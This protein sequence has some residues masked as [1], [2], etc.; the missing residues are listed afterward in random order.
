[1][2]RLAVATLERPTDRV[3]VRLLSVPDGREQLRLTAHKVTVPHLAFTADGTLVSIDQ[4]FDACYHNGRTGELLRRVSLAADEA[5]GPEFVRLSPRG[6]WLV[7]APRS[8]PPAVWDTTSGQRQCVLEGV[9]GTVSN[10]DFTADDQSVAA[11]VS[12]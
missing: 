4:R 12:D 11:R 7:R 1:G 9:A 10:V 2:G 6:R 5:V 3:N 8:G